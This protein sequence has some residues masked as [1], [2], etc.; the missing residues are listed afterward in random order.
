MSQELEVPLVAD[1]LA[2]D[3]EDPNRLAR[4][5]FFS[6]VADEPEPGASLVRDGQTI[7]FLLLGLQGILYQPL[8]GAAEFTDP[9]EINKL[10]EAIEGQTAE[11]PLTIETGLIWVPTS[12]LDAAYSVLPTERAD[13]RAER[14]D[15][16]RVR[17][18]LFRSLWRFAD[19]RLE[20][21]DLYSQWS[22]SGGTETPPPLLRYSREETRVFGQWTEQQF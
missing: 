1:S 7:P 22:Q 15:V 16:F 4:C 11:G 2:R 18:T 8:S 17:L 13:N 21:G 10:I 9:D 5:I 19:N 12:W 3:D 6:I 14:G 20:L